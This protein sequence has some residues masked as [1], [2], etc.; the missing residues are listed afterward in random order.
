MIFIL[1]CN[2]VYLLAAVLAVVPNSENKN[3]DLHSLLP[4]FVYVDCFYKLA[5]NTINYAIFYYLLSSF[6]FL[7]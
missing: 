4:P 1:F 3:L 6:Y 7:P 2:Y 5:L